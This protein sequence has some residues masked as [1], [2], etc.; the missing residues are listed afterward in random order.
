MAWN[1]VV[2]MTHKACAADGSTC[3]HLCHVHPTL[4]AFMRPVVQTW[5]LVSSY[6]TAVSGI[7]ISV[8]NLFTWLIYGVTWDHQPYYHF[9]EPGTPYRNS[10]AVRQIFAYFCDIRSLRITDSSLTETHP[11]L[12][13]C[14][15]WHWPVC[16]HWMEQCGISIVT[17]G[18]KT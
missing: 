17:G 2:L 12:T 16:G 18:V 6:D 10:W 3:R 14:C 7:H 15:L 8:N 13:D 11:R 9:S 1:P 5:L 4:C